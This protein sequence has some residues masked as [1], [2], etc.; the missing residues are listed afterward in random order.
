M[1]LTLDD[2]A[3]ATGVNASAAAI[4]TAPVMS[5]PILTVAVGYFLPVFICEEST[6]VTGARRTLAPDDSADLAEK[7]RFAKNPALVLCIVVDLLLILNPQ[8]QRLR[9]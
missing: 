2:E 7:T 4:A 1:V 8:V 5:D 9:M 6:E 3:E